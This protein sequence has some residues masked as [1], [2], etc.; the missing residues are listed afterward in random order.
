MSRSLAAHKYTRNDQ[1]NTWSCH[2]NLNEV[3]KRKFK[4]CIQ[5]ITLK[6]RFFSQAAKLGDINP[7]VGLGF[8]NHLLI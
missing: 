6:V 8:L 4:C 5:V 2:V 7:N 1:N 3:L